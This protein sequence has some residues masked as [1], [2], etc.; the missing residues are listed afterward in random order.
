MFEDAAGRHL[1]AVMPHP[2]DEAYSVAGTLAL[3]ASSGAQVSLVTATKG[4]AGWTRD[5]KSCKGRTLAEV[6]A[7]ELACSCA[8]MKIGEPHFLDWPDGRIDTLDSSSAAQELG[9]VLSALQP[10]VVVTLA[11]DGVYGHRD[12]VRL[13]QLCKNAIR[14][15]RLLLADFPRDLF[16]RFARRFEKHAPQFLTPTMNPAELGLEVDRAELII[17]IGAVATTK[18]AAIACHASQLESESPLE[19]L[20][21]GLVAAVTQKE[22]FSLASGP[23]LPPEARSPFAGLP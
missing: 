3:A 20:F 7:R 4:E 9:D 10:D 1:V 12:H 21:A 14:G 11:A 8:A 15:E 23:A 18:R 6:R 16:S 19:F 13:T 2:D 22:W 17:D 5:P